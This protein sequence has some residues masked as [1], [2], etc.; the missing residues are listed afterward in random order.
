[1]RR[2]G[3]TLLFAVGQM[4]VAAF[5]PSIAAMPAFAFFVAGSAL[6]VR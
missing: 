3:A 6:I 2:L 4:F 5:E 1:M